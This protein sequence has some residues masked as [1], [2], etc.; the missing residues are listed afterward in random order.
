[1]KFV[2]QTKLPYFEE[3]SK[4]WTQEQQ[5]LLFLWMFI[6]FACHNLAALCV[7]RPW[8]GFRFSWKFWRCMRSICFLMFSGYFMKHF[9]LIILP[10]SVSG[11]VIFHINKIRV[12]YKTTFDYVTLYLTWRLKNSLTNIRYVFCYKMKLIDLP[13]SPWEPELL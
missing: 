3:I 10:W 1:M 11:I 4:L 9:G 8:N 6:S 5:E 2:S 12:A 13:W 7:K